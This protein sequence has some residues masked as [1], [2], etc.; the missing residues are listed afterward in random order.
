MIDGLIELENDL[1]AEECEKYKSSNRISEQDLNT[2][3]VAALTENV[4]SFLINS[5]IYTFLYQKKLLD[6]VEIS[7]S[8]GFLPDGEYSLYTQFPAEVIPSLCEE[9][10]IV[11]LNAVIERKNGLVY[12]K[13]SKHNLIDK[14]AVYTRS[15]VAYEI[16]KNTLSRCDAGA[17]VSVLDFAC[18]TGRFYDCIV[19]ILDKEYAIPPEKSILNNIF[20]VDIDPVA[21]AI[22]RMKALARLKEPSVSDIE[23]I[24]GNIIR[25]NALIQ[26]N[27]MFSDECPLKNSDFDGKVN[28][29]FDV[30]VSNPPYFVDSL[31]CP[32]RQR[33]AARQ[34]D[35]KKISGNKADRILMWVSWFRTSG[36]YHYALEGMLNLYQLS[37]EKMIRMLKRNGYLGV[38]C[39][40][41][42]FADLSTTKLRK[43]LLEKNKVCEIKYFRESI[44]LFDNVTQST[45]IFY[46]QRYGI[47]G[48]INVE[49]DGKCFG[50]EIGSVRKIFGENMEIP[51]MSDRGWEILE[52]L[53]QVR[54]LKEY[55]EIRN[56]RG[57]LDLTLYKRFITQEQTPYRLVRGNMI[58]DNDIEDINHEYVKGEFL[59]TR[60]AEFLKCDFGRRRLVCQQVSNMGI[61][62]RLR[63]VYCEENDILGNSCNYISAEETVLKKMY[64]LLNS[65][66]LNWRFKVTSSNNHINNYEIDDLPV[67]DL[68]RVDENFT[69][70]SQEEL[71]RYVGELYG[72]TPEEINWIV[73]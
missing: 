10:H 62:R 40:S 58:A 63:F 59:G 8:Y 44:P 52:R 32:D 53:S 22:T 49:V 46:L 66:L 6:S 1:I 65:S 42:L 5:L 50:V 64:I 2:E 36:A 25:R 33:A 31:E 45:N 37:I 39:P 28:G 3:T 71:D 69:Y 23:K 18:G 47:T 70:S 67:V 20:A 19:D 48:R 13:K 51:L 7:G 56:R 16:V 4:H 30:I 60:S 29:G 41:T 11:F 38:I 27:I 9:L 72:L 43:F 34:P 35:K 68:N 17:D 15:Y 24:C 57:E 61:S 12:R 54:K 55:P 26:E 73:R 21:V 14:G